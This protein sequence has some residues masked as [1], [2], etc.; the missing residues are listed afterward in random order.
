MKVRLK[1]L[2]NNLKELT[3]IEKTLHN[4][5]IKDALKNMKIKIK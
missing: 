2:K 1:E 4:A 3:S 5:S